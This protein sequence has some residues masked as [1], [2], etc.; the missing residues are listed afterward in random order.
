MDIFYEALTAHFDK[1]TTKALFTNQGVSYPRTIDI[2]MGQPDNPEG[3][4]IFYPA[5]FVSWSEQKPNENE[6]ARLALFF[7]VLQNPGAGT[8]GFSNR[9]TEGLKYIKFLKA[10]QKALKGFRAQNTSALRYVGQNP[11]ITPF[12][13]YHIQNYQCFI[14]EVTTESYTDAEPEDIKATIQV[15]QKE[16]EL[17]TDI[18]TY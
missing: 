14:D 11:N 2:N 7:H 15:K 17:P 3:F 16:E 9:L 12:F 18:E 4:E 1:T 6:A 10:L 5:V 13:R 8:E